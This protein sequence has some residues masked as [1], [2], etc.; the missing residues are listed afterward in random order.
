[1]AEKVITNNNIDMNV[2]LIVFSV[3]LIIMFNVF[4]I[5]EVVY[6]LLGYWYYT[7]SFI[8]LLFLYY[9]AKKEEAI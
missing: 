6:V 8:L 7:F 1:M 2:F 9:I 3:F 5:S 4:G